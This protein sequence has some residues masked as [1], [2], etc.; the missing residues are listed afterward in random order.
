MLEY[1]QS[2]IA[3]CICTQPDFKD[4]TYRNI[5]SRSRRTCCDESCIIENLASYH[6]SPLFLLSILPD[7]APER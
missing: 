2:T 4:L 1:L 3:S 7:Q 5:V 6:K